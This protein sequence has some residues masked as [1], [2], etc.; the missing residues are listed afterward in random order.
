MKKIILVLLLVCFSF[1]GCVSVSRYTNKIYAPT[2]AN[3]IEVYSTTLPKRPY[4]E[5]AEIILEDSKSVHK[6]KK[7]GAKLGAD[8][9]IIL[10][11][12]SISTR[13]SWVSYVSEESGRKAIAIKYT[14]QDETE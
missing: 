11:S 13:A 7:E 1:L 8:A 10:G 14:N 2:D 5:I 9:I 3:D 6:L 4:I 12:A